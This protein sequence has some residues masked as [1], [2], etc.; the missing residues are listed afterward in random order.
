MRKKPRTTAHEHCCRPPPL[1]LMTECMYIFGHCDSP[2]FLHL[3][4][5][6]QV[7]QYSLLQ[8]RR[9]NSGILKH[10]IVLIILQKQPTL[11]WKCAGHK[12]NPDRPFWELP[13]CIPTAEDPVPSPA[14]HGSWWVLFPWLIVPQLLCGWVSEWVE[15]GSS[16]LF[17]HQE[18]GMG[19]W[20]YICELISRVP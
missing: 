14:Q 17:A 6:F 3:P 7:P 8:V 18:G 20:N 13:K 16:L 19:R 15:V 4:H 9:P 12:H 10:K 5:S 1:S 2:M 11:L